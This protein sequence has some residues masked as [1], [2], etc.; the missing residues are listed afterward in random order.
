MEQQE[1]DK[2]VRRVQNVIMQVLREC[3]ARGI[4]A[5]EEDVLRAEVARRLG[6]EILKQRFPRAVTGSVGR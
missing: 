5:V 1:Q 4:E 6:E 2:E 3:K